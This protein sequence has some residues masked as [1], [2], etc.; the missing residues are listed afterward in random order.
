[1][2]AG[3]F[4]AAQHDP[5]TW[6]RFRGSH[7]C[8]VDGV[9]AP[10]K[11][12]SIGVGLILVPEGTGSSV[13]WSPITDGDAPWIWVSYFEVGYEESVIDVVDMPGVTTFRETIDNKAMRIIRNQEVQVVLENA[14][15]NGATA[16]NWSMFGR[17]FSGT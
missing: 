12:C 2:I 14:T 4:A 5:E 3:T 13:L 6:L 1:M 15:I 17:A 16:V 7:L 9:S 11:L 10:G 8:Y